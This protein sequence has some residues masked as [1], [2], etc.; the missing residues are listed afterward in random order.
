MAG[1][2]FAQALAVQPNHIDVAPLHT[3]ES[4]NAHPRVS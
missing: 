3:L 2:R 4:A 1:P